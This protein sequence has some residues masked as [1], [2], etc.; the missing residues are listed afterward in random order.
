MGTVAF[1]V[2]DGQGNTS[3]PTVE[4]TVSTS[5]AVGVVGH[6]P[7]GFTVPA[8]ETWEIL[9]T[10]TTDANVVVEGTLRMRPG[11]TLRFVDVDE[12]AF[13]GGGMEVLASDVGLW[14]TGMGALDA[15]GTAKTAWTR[16][17][18]SLTA[19]QTTFDVE[20]TTGWQVGDR[21]AITPTGR[22]SSDSGASAQDV[23]YAL[24]YD[25]R[26]ITAVSG[27]TVTV[28]ALTHDHPLV[29]FNDWDGTPLAFGAEV[30][31]LTRDVRIEG[32]PG[33]RTHVMFLHPHATPQHISDIEI[34]HVGP[35]Q[36]GTGVLGRYGLH[37]HHGGDGTNGSTVDGVVVHDCG[38]HA[39][40]P[41]LSNGITM[42]DCVAHG[43]MQDAF[44]W[45]IGDRSDGIVW[46]RCVASKV[47]AE[48]GSIDYYRLAGFVLG[49]PVGN[50]TNA[51]IDCV[52]VGIRAEK[53]AANAVVQSGFHWPEGAGGAWAFAGCVA[54]NTGAGLFAWQNSEHPHFVEDFVAFHNGF[55]GIAHG[56]YQ[57]YYQYD[58]AALHANRR[59][60]VAC[61]AVTRLTSAT[62]P[63]APVMAFRDIAITGDG[64]TTHGFGTR[65][66]R[67]PT[68][69]RPVLLDR[70]TITGCGVS[71]NEERQANPANASYYLI[72]DSTFAA[73]EFWIASDAPPATLIVVEGAFELR[74]ADQPGTFISG[75]NASQ[76]AL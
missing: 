41:H 2:V 56:A 64:L 66:H 1:P 35:R 34:S 65:D 59:F 24:A 74:R 55:A 11:A 19:G 22:P 26:T 63:A 20:D 39:F 73:P 25:E 68:A 30:L 76:T 27:N 40:V 71:F 60:G 58:R 14:F 29:V 62:P 49:G 23:D 69:A 72:R 38:G 51:C 21:V 61:F 48:A 31:N 53:I 17:T 5:S 70:V 36:A 43:T 13:I 44:W 8:G 32:T 52:A 46:N 28:G 47:V 9:G 57:N 12:A 6:Q 33:G 3:S 15:H 54:H 42:T 7:G 4:V 67:F 10:V 18:S 37:F 45:D 75:W 16:A 50:D